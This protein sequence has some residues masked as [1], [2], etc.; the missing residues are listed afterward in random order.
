METKSKKGENYSPTLFL[1]SLGNGGLAVS[2]YIYLHFM[3]KHAKIDI[4]TAD[5][6]KLVKV[7]MV[8]FDAIKPVLLGDNLLISIMIGVAMAGILFFA[9]RHYFYLIWNVRKFNAWKKTEAYGELM[10]SNKEISLAAIPLTF[11]MSINVFFV[12]GGVFVPG[13]WNFVE[14]LFPVALL[15]FLIVGIFALRIYLRFMTRM[16]A[17]G[18]FDCA[19]NNSLSQMVAVF[20]FAMVG[21]G[22]AAPGAMSN[23]LVWSA[24]GIIGSMFFLSLTV[25]IGLQ[26]MF[27][28]FRA[29]MQYGINKENSPT[30]WI[31]VPIITLVGIALVRV[32][33]GLHMNLDVHTQ[34][35]E[36]FTSLFFLLSVQVV[37]GLLGWF[38]MK[39]VG[40]FDEYVH[41]EGK[42]HLSYALICPG[43]ALQV[44]SMFALHMGLVRLQVVPK[45]EVA[46]WILVGLIALLQIKTIQTVF[47][48][49]RKLLHP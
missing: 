13:L 27:M 20:A 36:M 40:Y 35:G 23:T 33:H 14:Y 30:L 8:T 49:D 22:F 15:G 32:D 3:L 1:A 5:A 7:P 46:Y 28:G 41:G 17:T 44:F 16:L 4:G 10:K 45:F 21:V 48:L 43:V 19:R 39:Q 18:D 37:F 42:S 2:F 31:I 38:V 47:K 12:L 6:P 24:L 11:S 9:A 29:M 25:L 26:S 34:P